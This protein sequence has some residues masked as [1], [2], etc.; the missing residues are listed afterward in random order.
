LRNENKNGNNRDLN[1]INGR[2]IL[3]FQNEDKLT[4]KIKEFELNTDKKTSNLNIV[5]LYLI[6]G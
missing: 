2:K 1:Q 4:K 6:L 5:I 3:Y